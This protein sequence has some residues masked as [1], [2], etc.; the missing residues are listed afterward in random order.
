MNSSNRNGMRQK[1]WWGL[2][3]FGKLRI[4]NPID[5]SINSHSKQTFICECGRNKNIIVRS[6]TS[7]KTSSCGQCNIMDKKWWS[8]KKFGHLKLKIP[9]QL[10]CLSKKKEIFVC[11]CGKEKA[12]AVYDVTSGKTVTCGLC[13]EMGADWWSN[14]KFGRLKL[15]SPQILNKHARKKMMF[16]CDC[17]NNKAISVNSVTSGR[18]RSCGNCADTVRKWF[19]KNQKQLR[20]IK[21][22]IEIDMFPSGG[23]VPLERITH[24]ARKFRALCPVCKS[25]YTPTISRL[26]S[27][28]GLT[29]GCTV[30]QTSIPCYEIFDAVTSNGYSATL[31]YV[32]QG[33]KYDIFIKESKVL[34]EFNG[35]LYHSSKHVKARDLKKKFISE[36]YGFKLI[37]LDD[38]EWYK[39]KKSVLKRIF[40]ELDSRKQIG[41][42]HRTRIELL[43]RLDEINN[44]ILTGNYTTEIKSKLE[45]RQADLIKELKYSYDDIM[46]AAINSH[47]VICKIKDMKPDAA[48]GNDPFIY[49]A[50]GL[51]GES[52][53]L[54]GALLRAIRNNDTIEA[55]KL[56]VESEIAD[57]IIYTVILAYTTGIDLI[58]IVNEKAKIV[59]QRALNG[60]YGGPI[61]K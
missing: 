10:N 32:L 48:Y 4:S 47:H 43:S 54:A 60:Y 61:N 56:A 41:S 7:G 53:E 51:V 52:G 59:A 35:H 3:K 15:A 20:L 12:I 58:K 5:L 25:V 57:C 31:E 45:K 9:R 6:V 26:K 49:Y 1:E 36:V 38:R 19:S 40:Q 11:D 2:Q 18:S 29:C 13:N 23:P 55:K 24:N 37:T 21:A 33:Y 22:P 44:M 16:I 34:I 46:S 28:H 30:Y 50:L 14:Q 39:N 27:G 8:I 17:G 42:N